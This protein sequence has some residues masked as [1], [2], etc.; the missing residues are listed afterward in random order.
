M[1]YIRGLFE[2]LKTKKKKLNFRLVAESSSKFIDLF[3]MKL[4]P[5]SHPLCI[6][7]FMRFCLFTDVIRKEIFMQVKMLKV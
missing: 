6:L 2:S 1:H 7:E 3:N 4:D 5:F